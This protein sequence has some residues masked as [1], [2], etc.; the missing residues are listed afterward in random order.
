MFGLF[1]KKKKEIK[2]TVTDYIDPSTGEVTK[3]SVKYDKNN[4]R[5]LELDNQSCAM[6]IHPNSKIEVV[7]TK[8]Y[9]SENQRVTVEEETLMAIALFMKQPGFAELLRKEFHSLA[10]NNISKITGDINE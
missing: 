2:S 8:L 3:S 1:K 9:D 6:I 4:S 10:M 7:F 5:F